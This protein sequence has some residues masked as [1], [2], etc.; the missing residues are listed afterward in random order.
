MGHI[1]VQMGLVDLFKVLNL[2][3]TFVFG[4]GI[5]ELVTAYQ[6]GILSLSQVLEMALV[7]INLCENLP[8]VSV[9][10]A[11]SNPDSVRLFLVFSNQLLRI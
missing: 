1:A 7:V 10:I 5:N 2:E 11:E 4:Y 8:M 6:D 3:P 9:Y